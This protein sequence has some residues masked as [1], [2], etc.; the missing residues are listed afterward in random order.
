MERPALRRLLHD[1]CA[2]KIDVVAV[3]KVDRLTRSLPDFARIIEAFDK[4]GVSFV[5]VTQ[6][7]NTTSSMGRLTLNVLLSFAQFEREVTGERIRDKIAASKA[8][9]MWMGGL[10]PLGYDPP[11][12]RSNRA[13]VVNEDEARTVRFIFGR[14]LEVGGLFAL[15][16]ALLAEGVR[17]KRW[18][19]ASGKRLG[20]NLF[21]RGAL[22]HLLQ[23]RT[24]LG[25]ISHQGKNH[26]GRHTAIL[27][28]Q[29]FDAAQALIASNS[30]KRRTRTPWARTALLYGILFDCDGQRMEPV[31]SGR[32]RGRRTGVSADRLQQTHLGAVR[33]TAVEGHGFVA[34]SALAGLGDDGIRIVGS[35]RLIGSEREIMR[36][37]LLDDE[38]LRSQQSFD[39]GCDVRPWSPVS[40]RQHPRGLDQGHG[41]DEPRRLR[42]EAFDQLRRGGGLGGFVLGEVSDE[43]IGVETDHAPLAPAIIAAFMSSRL[44]GWGGR[45]RM[46]FSER[47]EFEA[48]TMA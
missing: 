46:P 44:T 22:L 2:K 32:M 38:I 36:F 14:F 39:D 24:Y 12:S 43:H 18:T 21:S 9:G 29:T 13:L 33:S 42:G 20:G 4:A 7:F 8:K 45:R 35:G 37:R 48:G 26:S 17:S 23:N 31:L 40:P 11:A 28:P 34:A 6:A 41:G 15:Q 10:P 30:R 3:Y 1:I 5:S 25:E 47:I 27:D 16:Q 19:C